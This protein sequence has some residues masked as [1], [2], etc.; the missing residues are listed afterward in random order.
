MLAKSDDPIFGLQKLI[1]NITTKARML[2]N[3]YFREKHVPSTKILVS[4]DCEDV[5]LE[6]LIL[7]PFSMSIRTTPSDQHANV[8]Q[9]EDNIHA[10]AGAHAR[11]THG[12]RRGQAGHL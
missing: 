5:I 12:D 10:P 6:S 3:R 1:S 8:I 7:F 4:H 9:N 2:F 11:R